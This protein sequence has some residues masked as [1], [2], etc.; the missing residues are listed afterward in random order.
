MT[1]LAAEALGF[2]DG[3]TFDTDLVQGFLHLI[4]LEG[5]DDGF[6]LFHEMRSTGFSRMRATSRRGSAAR[7]PRPFLRTNRANCRIVSV[8]RIFGFRSRKTAQT[9]PVLPKF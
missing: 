3:D 9:L 6:D 1:L 7:R 8:L 5:L 2:D 4:Q